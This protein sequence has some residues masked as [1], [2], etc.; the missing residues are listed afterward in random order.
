MIP[1]SVPQSAKLEH[2][3]LQIVNFG[4]P[5][6]LG[7]EHVGTAQAQVGVWK[8][9]GVFDGAPVVRTFWKPSEEEL[10]FLQNNGGVVELI[11]FSE[12]MLVTSINVE[13]GE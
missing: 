11:Y 7:D 2:P 6:G 10:A 8:E 9:N 4:P 13:R 5:Q 3:Q 12:T 1:V